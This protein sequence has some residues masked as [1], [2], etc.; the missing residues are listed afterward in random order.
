MLYDILQK[1]SVKMKGSKVPL[2]VYALT[3][4]FVGIHYIGEMRHN[5]MV[6]LLMDQLTE[7]QLQW[8]DLIDE[9]D[10]VRNGKLM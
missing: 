9:F 8:C 1:R 2:L 3:S 7:G 5:T 4:L 6:R 10:V